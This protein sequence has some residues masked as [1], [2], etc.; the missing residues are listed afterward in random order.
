MLQEFGFQRLSRHFAR[1]HSLSPRALLYTDHYRRQ[2]SV[3]VQFSIKFLDVRHVAVGVD[4]LSGEEWH[5]M[6]GEMT[7]QNQELVLSGSGNIVNQ[8]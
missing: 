5:M 8:L 3:G 1:G 7:A 2:I 4:P 6:T